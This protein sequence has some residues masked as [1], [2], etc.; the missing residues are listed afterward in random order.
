MW[1]TLDFSLFRYITIPFRLGYW[2]EIFTSDRGW[3]LNNFLVLFCSLVS[4]S[5]KYYR[6]RYEI[7]H[8]CDILWMIPQQQNEW[9]M[10]WCHHMF[11]CKM[12]VSSVRSNHRTTEDNHIVADLVVQQMCIQGA[13][14]LQWSYR[15]VR[16]MTSYNTYFYKTVSILTKN[17][18]H[19]KDKQTSKG[20]YKLKYLKNMS[21]DDVT[22]YLLWCTSER[23]G[24]SIQ[25]T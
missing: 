10:L 7:G 24:R 3:S 14:Q 6:W 15:V 17:V 19:Y 21:H 22:G 5:Q 2:K 13:F 12:I 23:E 16:F 4:K 1:H 11:I 20:S 25:L 18:S 8:F 9:M